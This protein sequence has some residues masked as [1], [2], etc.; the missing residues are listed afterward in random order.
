M[1]EGELF[2]QDYVQGFEQIVGTLNEQMVKMPLARLSIQL[3]KAF[4]A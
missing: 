3:V 4:P 1:V 2:R